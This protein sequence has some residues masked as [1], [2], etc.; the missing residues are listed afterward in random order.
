MSRHARL[1]R[2]TPRRFGQAL[3]A[4]LLMAC[5]APIEAAHRLALVIGN[6]NY[7]HAD[8]LRNARSD[9]RAVAATLQSLGF[10]VTLKQDVTLQQMKVA[11]RTFKAQISGGDEVVF[12]FSGHGVQFGGTNYLIPVDLLPQNEEEVADDSVGLQRVLDDMS[13]QKARFSLAI[14]D[15]CR[16]NPFKSAGRSIGKKGLVMQAATGQM[17]MYS[18]GTGQEA[19]DHV[20]DH[21]TDPNGLFTRVLI[22]EIKKP[23]VTANQL[24]KNV[25]YQVVQVAK[26]VNHEQ[27]P[28]LY[29]QTIGDY[30]FVPAGPAPVPRP[31]PQPAPPAGAGGLHVQTAGELEQEYWNRIKDSTDQ[32]DFS[33]YQKQ[34]AQ[35]PHAAEAALALRKLKQRAAAARKSS[36]PATASSDVIGTPVSRSVAASAGEPT[37]PAGRAKVAAGTYSGYSTSSLNPGAV[38]RGRIVLSANGDFDA[39]GS[40]G[41]KVRGSLDLSRPDKIQGTATV[42]QPKVLGL[43]ISRYPDGSTTTTIAIHAQI[44]G[45]MLRGHYSDPFETGD[46]VFDLNNPM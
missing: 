35:G 44:V 4:L 21:D 13:D 39:T 46:L 45:G 19:L 31:Q 32:T 27:V 9:A 14:I 33:D 8:V 15:A 38:L 29:D 17:V 16:E 34:F 2:G 36:A 20:G 26:T 28:A 25:S 5:A 43:P 30:Y 3:A 37:P 23:G 40:N 11:L 42:T 41:V 1:A 24:L 7:Q 10:T 22:R 18:A 6:D 12:Y